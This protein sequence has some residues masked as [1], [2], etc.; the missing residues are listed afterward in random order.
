MRTQ[1]NFITEIWDR[2]SIQLKSA[3]LGTVVFGIISQG[4]GLFNKYSMD[5]DLQYFFLDDTSLVLKYGRWVWYLMIKAEKKLLG[6]TYSLP[7]FNGLIVILTIAFIACLIVDL[8]NIRSTVLCILVG[9]IMVSIP[10]I[11]HLLGDMYLAHHFAAA[12]LFSVAGPYL[13]LK[14]DHWSTYA[15]G[16]AMMICSTAIYQAYIPVMTAVFLFSFIKRI[17]DADSYE[18]MKIVFRKFIRV[19][20]CSVMFITLYFL[21]TYAINRHYGIVLSDIKG[22]SEMGKTPLN[23]YFQRLIAAYT[24]FFFPTQN[25][26]YNVFPGFLLYLNYSSI[27]LTILLCGAMLYRVRKE[28]VRLVTLCLLFLLVPLAVNFIFVI[29]DRAYCYVLML[30]GKA[31]FFV[32]FAWILERTVGNLDT[33]VGKS[34]KGICLGVLSIVVFLYCR[35]D[36]ICYLQMELLQTQAIRYFTTL[37]TRIQSTEGYDSWKYVSY[38]GKPDPGRNDNSI[39]PIPELDN[40][41]FFP[42]WGLKNTLQGPWKDYMKLWCGYSAHETD[43]SYFID[44]PEV[45]AMPH[46]PAEGS[47]K[48]IDDTIVVKF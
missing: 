24:E 40:I 17:I 39:E 38:I 9:G 14:K 41:M 43:Q 48:V 33:R 27:V 25:R 34:F 5:D 35:Y 30:Y 44:R 45:Q 42:Y 11:T 26:L 23:V 32:F 13:I 21:I 7:I 31:M 2:F 20:L 8:M 1:M 4:M 22:I 10:S 46:Y 18:Q 15:V 16:T 28:P 6:S 29:V 36:N 12:L 47:I 3:F 37:I 19:F